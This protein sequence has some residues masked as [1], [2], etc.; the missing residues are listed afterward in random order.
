MLIVNIFREYTLA[1][2]SR[3]CHQKHIQCLDLNTTKINLKI[4]FSLLHKGEKP[5]GH[6]RLKKKEKMN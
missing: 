1:Q 6:L 2:N 3:Y 5:V 4:I